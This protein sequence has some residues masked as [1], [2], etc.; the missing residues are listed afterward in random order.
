MAK[1]KLPPKLPFKRLGIAG[2]GLIGGSLAK[3]L[4]PFGGL[5]IYVFDKD[6][7]TVK[8]AKKIRRLSK[9][10]DDPSEF[11]SWPLDLAYLCLPV[12]KNVELI[13]LMGRQ[14]ITYPVTDAGSTKGPVT[15]AARNAG[16]VFCGGHPIS[17]REVSGFKHAA[18]DL[19]QGSLFILTPDESFGAAG[20][21]LARDLF[22]FH[23]LL[24]CRIKVMSP[25]EH[26]KIYALVSHLPYLAASALAGTVFAKGGLDS[27]NWAGTGFKDSTRIAAASP[28]KW[29]E[30]AL[31]NAENLVE[32]I[33]QLELVLGS[34]KEALA[35]KNEEA[36]LGLLEPISTFRQKL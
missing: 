16:L 31:D 18:A 11:I 12:K 29:V 26:D 15:L 20:E 6:P 22:D 32:N 33:E 10:T 8:A 4:L 27:L 35:A 28:P 2:L 21:K 13:E 30:I 14:G 7:E 1:I 36:L 34:I 3:A 19:W 24:D 9:V 23:K 17:G 5:E 25:S